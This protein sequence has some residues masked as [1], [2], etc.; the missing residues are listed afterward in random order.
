MKSKKTITGEQ[1]T[2]RASKVEAF[3]ETERNLHRYMHEHYEVFETYE[4][5]TAEY[6]RALED[7]E[8]EARAL[9]KTVGPF[10]TAGHQV[11]IDVDRLFEELGEDNFFKFGGIIETKRVYSLDREKFERAADSGAIP[12]EI[13]DLCYEKKPK[14]RTPKRLVMP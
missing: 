7:A 8:K 1:T 11:N 3:L 2:P 13:L 10:V 4:H 5:L 14:F 12:Q 6:N 9:G